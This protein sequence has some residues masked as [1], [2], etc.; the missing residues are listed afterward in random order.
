M[1]TAEPLDD[2]PG[3]RHGFFTREGG[4]SEGAFE[5]L[6]CGFGS[7]DAWDRVAANRARAMA[8][9]GAAPECLATAYRVH[10]HRV[11]GGTIVV[12]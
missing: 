11:S 6:N 3:L 9:I 8:R 4:V 1:L 12:W 5:S 7:G 2:L 10:S